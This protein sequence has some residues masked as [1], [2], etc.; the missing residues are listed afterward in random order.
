MSERFWLAACTLTGGAAVGREPGRGPHPAAPARAS[1]IA[2]SRSC[3]RIPSPFIAREGGWGETATPG[4]ALRSPG[5]RLHLPGRGADQHPG[6][7]PAPPRARH[8]LKGTGKYVIDLS[9]ARG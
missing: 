7:E 6:A 3:P 9:P 4:G 2:A 1:S 8:S 5:R